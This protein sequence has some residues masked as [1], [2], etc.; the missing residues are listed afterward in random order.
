MQGKSYSTLDSCIVVRKNVQTR[1]K[2]SRPRKNKILEPEIQMALICF[3]IFSRK[4]IFVLFSMMSIM[5]YETRLKATQQFFPLAL[6]YY[7]FL[8]FAAVRG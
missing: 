1:K 2:E 4:L 6:H 7:D 8:T 3:K 5:Q